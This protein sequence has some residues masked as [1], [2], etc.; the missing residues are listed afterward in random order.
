MFYV[1]YV[2]NN[3]FYLFLDISVRTLF[4]RKPHLVQAAAL[5][6]TGNNATL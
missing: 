3:I 2:V 6:P 4:Y 5:E 1:A